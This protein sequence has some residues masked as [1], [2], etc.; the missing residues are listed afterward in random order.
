ME[1]TG[2]AMDRQRWV[3]RGRGA[4]LSAVL[5]GLLLSG[6]AGFRHPVAAG[7]ATPVPSASV[8]PP[9]DAAFVRLENSLA[10]ATGGGVG[11][12]ATEQAL[13]SL[14][15]T[16]QRKADA[17]SLCAAVGLLDQI[18]ATVGSLTPSIGAL[19]T[20]GIVADVL[21]AVASLLGD[22]RS[23]ACGG[24]ARQPSPS[25]PVITLGQSDNHGALV[26][27]VLPTPTFAAMAGNGVPF[28]RMF[29]RGSATIGDAVGDPELPLVGLQLA[30][31]VG[32]GVSV[33]V[34]GTSGYHLGGVHLWPKQAP[35]QMGTATQIPFA[36]NASSYAS[37]TPVPAELATAAAPGSLRN[38]RVTDVA[39]QTAQYLPLAQ[40]LHV[41]TGID[42]QVDFIGAN[43]GVFGSA[44]IEDVWEHD[45]QPLYS[46][47]LNRVTA[48]AFL[49]PYARPPHL[50]GEQMLIVSS[51][52]ARSAA[53]R[54]ALERTRDGILTKVVQVGL[55]L[56]TTPAAIRSYIASEYS[57]ANCAVHPTH[58]LLM[59]EAVGDSTTQV[60]TW[61]V[62]ADAQDTGVGTASDLPY[63]LL[64]QAAHIDSHDYRDVHPDLWVSRIPGGRAA[65]NAV[66]K[67][68]G[69]EDQPP[70]LPSFYSHAA[71]LSAFDPCA[72]PLNSCKD[73]AGNP[74]PMSTRDQTDALLAVENVARTAQVAGA[75][76]DR[77][78]RDVPGDNP[79]TF[80]DGTPLPADMHLGATR[81]DVESDFYHGRFLVTYYYHGSI[82]G[83]VGPE[84]STEAAGVLMN[85]NLLPVVW[86]VG[87]DTGKFDTGA[88][89]FSDA[90]MLNG[91]GGAVGVYAPSRLTQSDT[92]DA[93]LY[94][95]A[96]IAFPQLR[97]LAIRVVTGIADVLPAVTRLGD[98]LG[99][100]REAVNATIPATHADPRS[101]TQNFEF[102]SFGDPTMYM[103]TAQPQ[104][105][106]T[107]GI[108]TS[109]AP[110]APGHDVVVTVPN[111]PETEGANVTLTDG[112]NYLGR[113]VI[114]NGRALV[115]LVADVPNLTG[116][117]VI[118]EKGG[119]V[120]ARV[121]NAPPVV[122]F[123][124]PSRGPGGGGTT[125]T[126]TGQNLGLVSDVT[127]GGAPATFTVT[128]D[129]SL[130]LVTPPGSGIADVVVTNPFGS[131][132]AN[133]EA[134]FTYVPVVSSLSPSQGVST[135]GTDVTISGAGFG[136]TTS[137]MFGTSAATSFQVVDSDHIS[138]VSPPGYGA[139]NVTVTTAA[140]ANDET[141]SFSYFGPVL[142]V[143]SVTPNQVRWEPAL[144]SSGA[145]TVTVQGVGFAS[146][147][148]VD[149]GPANP[150]TNLR[151]VSDSVL[152]VTSPPPP[153]AAGATQVVDVVVHAGSIAS[154]PDANDRFT[155]KYDAPSV[156]AVSPA[157]GSMNG[158]NIVTVLGS[159][160]RG[161][162]QVTFGGKPAPTMRVVD[163][164]NIQVTVPSAATTGTVDVQVVTPE[165]TSAVSDADHYA[166]SQSDNGG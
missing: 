137:V 147:T 142:A 151:I 129:R 74:E 37:L 83:W 27:I 140:G 25:V 146:A 84:L 139:V 35:Q 133:H 100:A 157:G 67:T 91:S 97:N 124:T 136:G 128:D 107:A 148:S 132:A 72:D 70:E 111:Q 12:V 52:A 18:E 51:A 57:R 22:P 23:A 78:V 45:A 96:N 44:V 112:D 39:V 43:T 47:L 143:S 6:L 82:D 49:A 149:F 94:N 108:T 162:T 125:V 36:E 5:A 17:G 16:A 92:D 20:T 55:G 110:A 135:G 86:T 113:G 32:A 118:L 165:G 66:A 121:T 153:S 76:V 4:V 54:L 2:H 158:G 87:C 114:S 61:T 58:V 152:T 77:L 29:Q 53:D 115:T 81:D 119:F 89:V 166:Y 117:T 79:Q 42:L 7:A 99:A 156:T 73:A 13:A 134:R 154:T 10:S 159:A 8:P 106:R 48:S 127:V 1:R 101:I 11:A 161:A 104:H 88:H 160:F 144:G 85:A 14:A 64:H 141:R 95:L 65:L 21:S 150:G 109:L 163:D 68:I 46:Q 75:T 40:E 116:L 122:D 98:T 9:F 33:R 60:P 38:L 41:Y 50:C 59:G 138:A 164:G 31:P 123:I 131:S 63:G 3:R 30:V 34:V 105:F 26:H 62:L 71:V 28:V 155:Y 15:A 126:L 130:T 80:N 103:W 56:G 102:N 145:T 24:A 120:S 90:L 69:Y 19:V 93:L